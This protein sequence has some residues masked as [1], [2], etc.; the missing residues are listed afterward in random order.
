[1]QDAEELKLI[2]WSQLSEQS[3][4]DESRGFRS[5]YLS[6]ALSLDLG[7]AD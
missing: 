5:L 6:L 2:T 4:L 7:L 3:C 1:M